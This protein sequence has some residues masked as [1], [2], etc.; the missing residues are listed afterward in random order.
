MRKWV[1]GLLIFLFLILTVFSII[2]GKKIKEISV[3]PQPSPSTSV[4]PVPS[5]S[6]DQ[7]LSSVVAENLDVPWALAFL[8]DKSIL[9][10]E[11]S[12]NLRLISA[13]GKL[14]PLPIGTIAEV[15]EIGEG[16]LLGVAVHPDFEKNNFIYVYYT[17]SSNYNNTRNRVVRYKFLN[18]QLS[19]KTIIVDNIPGNSNH[20]GG[21][22]K[23]GPDGFL[24]IATGDSQEPSLAQNTTSLAGKILRVTDSGKAAP[25]NP[26]GSAQGGSSLIY[27]YGHRNPQGLTWDG[28]EQ[29]WA[30]EHGRSGIQSGLDELN[31]IESG[32]NYGWPTIQGNENKAGMV[33]PILNSGATDTWA[34][35]GAAFYPRSDGDGSVFFAGLRGQGLYEAVLNGA[36]VSSL[37]KHFD[38]E[39]GRI[40]DVVL[41]PDGF[42]YIT[43]SNRD[44]RGTPGE[45]D[46]KI[47]RVNPEKL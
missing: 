8:P 44:G 4:T 28:R 26:F 20:D 1:A 18:N 21:R 33:T 22:I 35:S 43:T 9:F 10:T 46:D 13:D 29:L 5:V 32:K 47:L 3:V 19:E 16:G 6:E 2:L 36:N 25:G 40:R 15:K 42:L 12:G 24:Y 45:S 27:S 38:H 14:R 7:P 30:T 34:P 39:F 31:M 11:R 23:F 37:K 41:G 17:Y